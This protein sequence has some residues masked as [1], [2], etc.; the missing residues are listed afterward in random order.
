MKPREVREHRIDLGNGAQLFCHEW[1]GEGPTLIL[2]HPSGGYGFMWEWVAEA[3]G[4]R[5]HIYAPDQR[6]HGRSSRPDG[7]Y[8]A[9]EYA[10]DLAVFM[11]RLGIGKAVVVGHSLGGRAA[12]AFAGN[13]PD[14]AQALVLVGGP[15]ASNFRGTRESAQAILENAYSILSHAQRFDTREE[16]VAFMQ[17][18][19]PTALDPEA[20]REH[21]LTH[22]YV[23][24]ADGSIMPRYDALRVAQGLIHQTVNLRPH[25]GRVICPVLILRGAQSRAL[26]REQAEE[27]ARC[28][29]DAR[30]VDVEGRYT[31]Q[32]EDPVGTANAITAFLDE[33][34]VR[35]SDSNRAR[36]A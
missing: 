16:L 14:R 13:H 11:D 36:M 32:F 23:Q 30:V 3:L 10:A 25:A 4:D 12:Q 9:D 34:D 26:S 31:L 20:G 2:L 6:G 7:D 27:M 21:R 15:H 8:S 28:W 1:P 19:H 24:Q 22:N 18:T 17:I 29:K 35:C 5:Y 33:I